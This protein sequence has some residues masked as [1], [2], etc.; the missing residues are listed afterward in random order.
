[1]ANPRNYT[2]DTDDTLTGVTPSDY[3]TGKGANAR[4]RKI[5][6]NVDIAT[7]A[8]LNEVFNLLSSAIQDISTGT[9]S[10]YYT[11]PEANE[12]STALSTA[13]TGEIDAEATARQEADNAITVS[14]SAYA[15]S[16]TVADAYK[17]AISTAAEGDHDN[18]V[19][20]VTQ[21][22]E[23]VGTI[24]IA[25]DQFVS[26]AHFEG[27]ILVLDL[28]NGDEISTD[29]SGLVD[30]Y[31]GSEDSEVK[32]TTDGNVISVVLKDTIARVGTSEDLSTVNTGREPERL[33]R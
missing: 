5:N 26:A 24:D 29:L 21:G 23:T 3:E 16:T 2:Q 10:N 25:K 1:M 14:L 8:E 31:N 9:L 12:I 17:V 22:N 28:R 15:L 27:T 32:V 7:Q 6:L 4:L 11:K 33:G 18:Y 30:V 20:T 19:Y 13:L